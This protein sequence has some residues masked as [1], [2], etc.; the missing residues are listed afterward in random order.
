MASDGDISYGA[1]S[2]DYGSVETVRKKAGNGEALQASCEQRTIERGPDEENSIR[3]DD[4][5]YQIDDNMMMQVRAKNWA[6]GDT[7]TVCKYSIGGTTYAS[8]ARDYGKVQA[9]KTQ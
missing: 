6:T 1:I 8:I 9:T 5:S 2:Q 4:G 7:V 3:L